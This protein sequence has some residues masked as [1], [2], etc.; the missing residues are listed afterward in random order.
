MDVETE[1][2]FS[3]PSSRNGFASAKRPRTDE[4]EDRHA[5]PSLISRDGFERRNENGLFFNKGPDQPIDYST[6]A[7]HF[8]RRFLPINAS[9]LVYESE[10]FRP[11]GETLYT[12]L[13]DDVIV[14]T[15][16]IEQFTFTNGSFFIGDESSRFSRTVQGKLSIFFTT[17]SPRNCYNFL[18]M[19]MYC[20]RISV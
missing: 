11:K 14:N 12:P 4:A 17:K 8:S 10:D 20:G 2:P 19:L 3:C 9:G 1:I 16:N 6:S 5:G 15:R 13:Q 18:E 7:S